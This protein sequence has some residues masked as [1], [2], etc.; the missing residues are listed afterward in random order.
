LLTP[1]IVS[2]APPSAAA[3]PPRRRTH[4]IGIFTPNRGESWPLLLLLLLLLLLS[5]AG[6]AQSRHERYRLAS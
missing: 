3:A 4:E 1:D 2:S 6:V 5:A